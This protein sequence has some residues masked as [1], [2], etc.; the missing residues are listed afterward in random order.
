MSK[1]HIKSEKARVL[2]EADVL[3]KQAGLTDEQVQAYIDER[4]RQIDVKAIAGKIDAYK[5]LYQITGQYTSEFYQYEIA[6]A[7]LAADKLRELGKDKA[8]AEVQ[9]RLEAQAEI[10]DMLD[11]DDFIDGLRAKM[12]EGAA[13]NHRIAQE[14]HRLITELVEGTQRNISDTLFGTMQGEFESISDI[15]AS[16]GDSFKA[17]I[18]RMAADILAAELGKLLFGTLAG[19]QGTLS[20]GTGSGAGLIGMG[21]SLLANLFGGS[22]GYVQQPGGMSVFSAL[23]AVRAKGG[24]YMPGGR[25]ITAFATGGVIDRP[26]LFGYSEGMGVMGEAG[27]EAI[28]PLKKTRSG[29][30]G[31][32]VTGESKKVTISPTIIVQAPEGRIAKQSMNQLTNRL[33]RTL[34]NSVRRN[35]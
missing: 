17:M 22:T 11:S 20:S 9:A 6:Q 23:A 35:S 34:N 5:Q 33:G 2:L 26:T 10:K 29:N 25:E 18:D 15:F 14:A 28:L 13:E 3:K 8:A 12:K 27:P 30:L 16:L 4:T 21:A 7:K 24:A 19:G 31:V 1:E 32:E